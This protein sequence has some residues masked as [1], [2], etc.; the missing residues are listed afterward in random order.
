MRRIAAAARERG[1]EAIVTT[2]K[3]AVK[4][5]A[6]DVGMPVLAVQVEMCVTPGRQFSELIFGAL[7]SGSRTHGSE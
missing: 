2:E 6:A 4:M 3:D 7:R 5:A 1:G